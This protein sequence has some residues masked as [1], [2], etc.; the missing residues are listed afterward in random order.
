M[1]AILIFSACSIITPENKNIS[2]EQKM[3]RADELFEKK[4]Y[5]RAAEFYE[6]VQFERRKSFTVRAKFQLAN[7]YFLN[8][9]YMESRFV[10]EDFI[11][12]YPDYEKNNL[13]YFRIGVCFFEDSSYSHFS[14]SE[15]IQA[16]DAF[17]EFLELYPSDKNRL[18]AVEYVK[19]C[20]KKMLEKKFWNG[21]IYYKLF[22]Y[23]ASMLYLKEVIEEGTGDEIEA[24][25]LFYII[26]ILTSWDEQEKAK[27]YFSILKG[28]HKDSKFIKKVEKLLRKNSK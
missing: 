13:A 10:Y 16:A 14:Q 4:K 12:Q 18:R 22:D 24:K 21:Y 23:S 26:K 9:D 8:G 2:I 1:V 20:Q 25:A 19:Q 27:A 15:T 6:A 11:R 3:T 5:S 7:C 28:G 17:E